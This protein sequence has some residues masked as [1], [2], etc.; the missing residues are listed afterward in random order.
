M[1]PGMGEHKMGV[2][3]TQLIPKQEIQIQGAGPPSLLLSPI[4]SV[5]PLK[6]MQGLK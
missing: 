6:L 3:E 2:I 5:L 4:A 1:E